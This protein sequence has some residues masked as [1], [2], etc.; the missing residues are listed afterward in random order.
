[1]I[2][3]SEI[4]VWEDE[5]GAIAPLA[6]EMHRTSMNVAASHVEWE[7][8]IIRQVNLEF[9]LVAA[10]LRSVSLKQ[11][12]K[13]YTETEFALAILEDK[14]AEVLSRKRAGY[15]I[16]DWQAIN[17]QVLRMI[18]EYARYQAIRSVRIATNST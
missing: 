15:F 8:I 3:E 18:S 10:Y 11:N 2:K 4:A 17:A 12:N 16:H 6:S 9:D 13:N 1:M 5:G 14:R 7:E